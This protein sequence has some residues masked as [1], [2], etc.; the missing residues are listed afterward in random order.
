MSAPAVDDPGAGMLWVVWSRV[1]NATPQDVQPRPRQSNTTRARSAASAPEQEL[2]RQAGKMHIIYTRLD[3]GVFSLTE[4]S[5]KKSHILALPGGPAGPV[6]PR[7]RR[8]RKAV[9]LVSVEFPGV[10]TAHRWCQAGPGVV[11]ARVTSR[12]V[13]RG[14]P[15]QHAHVAVWRTALWN[16][17]IDRASHVQQPFRR[18]TNTTSS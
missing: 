15:P 7:C 3:S 13:V 17:G 5:W 9:S 14:C 11:R 12:P 4:A 8:R 1:P 18:A 16:V 10:F 2:L 6:H